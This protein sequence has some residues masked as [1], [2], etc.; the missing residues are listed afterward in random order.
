MK[1]SDSSFIEV[2]QTETHN[3][4][5]LDFGI[6]TLKLVI[7]NVYEPSEPFNF[8][9]IPLSL[10]RDRKILMAEVKSLL[11]SIADY[12]IQKFI[13]TSTASSVF[14]S[15]YEHIKF[16]NDVV[17]KFIYETNI[18]WWSIDCEFVSGKQ[19]ITKPEKVCSAGWKALAKTLSLKSKNTLI[20]E[21]GARSTSIIP[22]N[23]GKIKSK[24]RSDFERI[25]SK[26]LLFFG[27]LETNA[28]FIEPILKINNKEYALSWEYHANT[29][30]IFLVSE[31]IDTSDYVNNT[32][33]GKEKNIKA[34]LKRIRKMFSINNDKLI[35]DKKI[36]QLIH[37]IRERLLTK[38]KI[39]IENKAKES[40]LNEVTIVGVG[41]NIL[42]NFLH[43][44]TEVLTI[45]KG[46]QVFK[47][48]EINPAY[49]IAYLYSQQFKK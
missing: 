12:Q 26:E 35:D 23:N 19:A 24:A 9:R 8:Q 17:S 20:V 22:I 7:M 11:R 21:F 6:D 30:D 37:T 43:E 28:A 13:L 1:V 42:Y 44:K 41:D 38:I 15:A 49:C 18:L 40:N 5:I 16:I 46:K 47:A 36:I 25:Q 33:D 4:C 14:D 39:I 29:A 3:I 34:A 45:K 48:V 27:A 10:R 2:E 31:D 32:P